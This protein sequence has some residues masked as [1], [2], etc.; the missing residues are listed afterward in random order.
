MSNVVQMPGVP[1]HK[2]IGQM[3]KASTTNYVDFCEYL[4]IKAKLQR[5][6]YLRLIKEGFNHKE[7]LELSKEVF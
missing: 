4:S 3:A 2:T 1:S 7:A 5:E 6:Y